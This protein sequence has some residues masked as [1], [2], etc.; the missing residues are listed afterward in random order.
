MDVDG[1]PTVYAASGVPLTLTAVVATNTEND[2]L[3]YRWSFG[4][5]SPPLSPR[6]DPFV[7]HTY[8]SSGGLVYRATLAVTDGVHRPILYEFEV[9]LD[10]AS[11]GP[12][13]E[14]WD[15][16]TTAPSSFTITFQNNSGSL[17]GFTSE[18]GLAMGIESMGVILWID[19]LMD[20]SGTTNWG[21]GNTYFGNIDR[22]AG[23]MFGVVIGPLGGFFTFDG[24]K[25]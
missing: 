5:G 11:P 19:A 12:K 9:V 22:E 2:R 23:T 13:T 4:D 21:T 6:D 16:T 17:F 10:G 7:T 15:V 20:P 24:I 25:R 3:T 14:T 1:Y 8:D 18:G